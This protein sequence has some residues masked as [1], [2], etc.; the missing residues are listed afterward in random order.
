M[1][2]AAWAELGRA[3]PRAV[4][5]W[6]RLITLGEPVVT[7][8]A[9]QGAAFLDEGR[10]HEAVEVLR[11]GVAAGE[12]HAPDLLIRAYL[13]SG[14]W[15]CV[16]DW[17]APLV[18]QGAVRYARRLGVALAEI[19]DVER[20]DE[21]LR[22]AMKAGELAAVNDLAILLCQRDRLAEAVALLTG[23][24]EAGDPRAGANLSSVLLESG[25][26]RRAAEA[27]EAYLHDARPDTFVALGDVRA[28]QGRADDAEQCYRRAIELGAMRAIEQ[29]AV[30]AHTAY[31][32]FL[33]EVRGDVVGAEREHRIAAERGEPGWAVALGRFLLDDDRPDE[34]RE[35]FQHALDHGDSSVLVVLAEIDGEDPY[36]D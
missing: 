9:A 33:L 6:K 2:L 11:R 13:E 5:S 25:D 21:V 14:H 22:L 34:A 16:V 3:R 19:G 10:P 20:A 36:E 24:A 1:R 15:H 27:A 30:R 23:A 18:D 32:G 35:Y 29:G 7:T 4:P 31:G 17:L 26:L 8:L 12:P 28:V